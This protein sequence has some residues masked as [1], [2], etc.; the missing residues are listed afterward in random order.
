MRKHSLVPN[1]G[2]SLSQAQSIS[3]LCNQRSQ[4]ITTTLSIVNNHS[5]KVN[6]E[7]KDLVT[8]QG[9]AMPD[10]VVELLMEKSKLHACQAFLMEN[11]KSKDSMLDDLK[12]DDA[13]I[14]MVT[15]PKKP[16]Y[17]SLVDGSLEVVNEDFGWEELTQTE[18]NEYLEAEAYASH[19]GQFIHKRSVLSNLRNNLPTIPAIDWMELKSGEKTPVFI[20][21]HHTPEQLFK[22][23]EDLSNHHRQYEQRVNYFKAKVKNL[24]TQENARIAKHNADVLNEATKVNNGLLAIYERELKSANDEVNKINADF[25]KTRQ[26]SIKETATLRINVDSRFQETVDR[27][28]KNLT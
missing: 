14:S 6:H 25:E 22:L 26:E 16:D 28:L 7:G 1:K 9:N 10:N 13:D 4:E 23:H 20:T 15:F 21:V 5:E 12:M 8:L 11:I 3:N 27:F 19:I 17:K 24:T 18:Y 2:L